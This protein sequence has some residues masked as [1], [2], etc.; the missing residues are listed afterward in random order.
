MS[1]LLGLALHLCLIRHG[2]VGAGLLRAPRVAEHV[3][4]VGGCGRV[5]H[6][7]RINW[8]LVSSVE[9]QRGVVPDRGD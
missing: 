6:R 5:Y 4:D 1:L 7:A 8:W 9:R 3:G 2:I